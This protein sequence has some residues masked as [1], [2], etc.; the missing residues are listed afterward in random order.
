LLREFVALFWFCTAGFA[1]GIAVMGFGV[2]SFIWTTVGKSL[3][4]V[5]GPYKYVSYQVQG[6]FAAVFFAGLLISLPF[7]RLPPPDYK[8]TLVERFGEEQSW[9]G[10]FIRSLAK[11][12]SR[13]HSV[14]E[15]MPL[16]QAVTQ[17]EFLL[18]TV[19]VFGQ[20]ITGVVFLSSAADMTQYIFNQDANTGAFIVSST[21]SQAHD[22]TW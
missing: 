1:T 19:V 3:M 10:W 4:D 18:L 21:Q 5:T 14:A 20:F 6:I 12:S 13:V 11:K 7:M 22:E 8:P 2:G 17:L 16:K 15:S 9:R